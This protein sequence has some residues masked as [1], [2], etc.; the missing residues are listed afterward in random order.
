V[1]IILWH[2][3]IYGFKLLATLDSLVGIIMNVDFFLLSA[4]ISILSLD[5]TIAFQ[6]LISSPIFSCTILG[7]LLGDI[8]LGMEL[9]FIFQLL[10]LGKIPTG[11]YIVPEGNI[12]SMIAAVLILMNRGNG[13]EHTTLVLVFLEA[14]LVSYLGSQLT[15]YYRKFN[16]KIL[17]LMVREVEKIHF[18]ILL[19]LEMGSMFSYFLAV[20]F[21]AYLV[22]RLSQLFLP[23]LIPLV[24]RLFENQFVVA[25]PVIIGI[26]LA[27][28][29]PLL[30]EA[31]Q[32]IPGK[33]L[34]SNRSVWNKI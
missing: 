23:G 7:W 31:F 28:I 12:A 34:E 32:K 4:V 14:I 30:K 21:L 26:G 27:S 17:D 15:L 25:K 24:G 19:V 1:F 16:G 5:I 10:W 20:F 2:Q 33:K 6:V 29:Y 9:G 11:A 22:L 18:N 8:R 13:W 3:L